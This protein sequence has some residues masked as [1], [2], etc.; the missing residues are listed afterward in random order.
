MGRTDT[1]TPARTPDAE[2]HLERDGVRIW[3]ESYGT[4][5]PVVLLL[6]PWTIVHSRLWKL[7]IPHLARHARVVTFDARGSGL[8]DAPADPRAYADAETIAD[9]V[10]ILDHLGVDA[11]VAAGLSRGARY[12]LELAAT[13]P[14][15][16]RSV[17]AL[18]PA[19]PHLT[20][21]PAWRDRGWTKDTPEY[22]QQDFR[23][24]LEFF[25]TQ[26]LPEPHS[27]KAL[28]D[29]VAWGLDTTPEI[30][31]MTRGEQGV[32]DREA[33]EALCRAVRC[34]VVVVQG[35]ADEMVPPER[36]TAP[37]PSSR[38]AGSSSSRARGTWRSCATPS[39]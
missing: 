38:A 32:A 29:G 36:G 39:G 31:A 25:F 26:A 2:G 14:D 19:V 28:E 10:A 5:E 20:D 37:R 3:W 4:G 24:F 21:E 33:A 6:P 22:W 17:V 1:G 16:V 8:S 12:A 27:T 35:T 18:G 7:Q 23:G 30:L 9:A 15:R 34:P 13:H 11:V